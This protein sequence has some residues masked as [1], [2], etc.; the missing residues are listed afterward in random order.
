[1]TSAGRLTPRSS[2][3]ATKVASRRSGRPGS[4]ASSC[5]TAS[6]SSQS[7]ARR[8]SRR[9]GGVAGDSE[10]VT[11]RRVWAGTAGAHRA[12]AYVYDAVFVASCPAKRP[13]GR[14]IGTEERVLPVERLFFVS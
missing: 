13:E 10:D 14:P 6:H 8:G 11:C 12:C 1:M 7:E 3:Q 5:G 2:A 4:W 9:V